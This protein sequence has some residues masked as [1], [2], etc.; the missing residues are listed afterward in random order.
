MRRA[1]LLLLSPLLEV[2]RHARLVGEATTLLAH[3]WCL[4]QVRSTHLGSWRSTHPHTAE[5]LAVQDASRPTDRLVSGSRMWQLS[6]LPQK[7]EE[8][9]VAAAHNPEAVQNICDTLGFLGD[10]DKPLAGPDSQAPFRGSTDALETV[11]GEMKLLDNSRDTSPAPRQ[12]APISE[13]ADDPTD[14]SAGIPGLGEVRWLSKSR[15]TSPAPQQTAPISESADDPTDASAGIAGLAEVQWLSKSRD[16]SPVPQ[17]RN[18]ELKQK[19]NEKA[20]Q[21][22]PVIKVDPRRDNLMS[23][24]EGLMETVHSDLESSGIARVARYCYSSVAC[25]YAALAISLSARL[26]IVYCSLHT[27]LLLLCLLSRWIQAQKALDSAVASGDQSAI[28]AAQE[29]LDQLPPAS[30]PG[31]APNAAPKPKTL[32]ASAANI[33]SVACT[34]CGT[35]MYADSDFCRKC[36]TKKPANVGLVAAELMASAGLSGRSRQQSAQQAAAAQKVVDD[37]MAARDGVPAPRLDLFPYEVVEPLEDPPPR[38]SCSVMRASCM[39][40]SGVTTSPARIGTQPSKFSAAMVAMCSEAW[41][42]KT[43]WLA[44]RNRA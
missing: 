33:Q 3:A 29:Q 24:I 10:F 6:R 11:L 18:A 27:C 21:Q 8:P 1:W 30:P 7:H 36:G 31:T 40:W 35:G 5:L 22:Q 44:G 20:R 16:T 17:S 14:A 28:A 23:R 37:L 15:D 9:T 12:T 34:G 4:Q 26:L 32:G 13:N 19:L 42:N 2:A 38:S 39:R 41:V 25:L 43:L